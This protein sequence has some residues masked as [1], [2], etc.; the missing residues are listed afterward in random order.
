MRE[1]WE[2]KTLGEVSDFKGGSQPPKSQFISEPREGYIRMLQIRDFKSDARAVYIPNSKK[3]NACAV[4][5]IMIG[6]YGASVGQI[7]RGKTGA[8]NVALIRTIPNLDRIDR[9]FFY[10][11]LTSSLFQKPLAEVSVRGAQNGFSKPD[12]EPFPIP[13]PPLAEQKRIVA[14]LD[15][16]FAGIAVALAAASKNLKNA[17]ELFETTLNATFTQKGEGWVEE[18]LANFLNKIT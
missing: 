15:E 7:H 3:T 12:I 8:Y 4:D 5:D 17:R 13:L 2:I 11:F 6:R 18:P 1:G 16:A 10:Y 14:L 9:D